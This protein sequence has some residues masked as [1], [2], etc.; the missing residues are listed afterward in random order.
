M[1]LTVDLS[2][3]SPLNKVIANVS[4][5]EMRPLTGIYYGFP[6]VVDVENHVLGLG[7]H[8]RPPGFLK[9]GLLF[10]PLPK[11]WIILGPVRVEESSFA[12]VQRVQ[13]GNPNPPTKVGD[14][15]DK[16][17]AKWWIS[18]FTQDPVHILIDW[19]GISNLKDKV[20]PV[21]IKG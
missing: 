3:P 9:E 16:V 12:M 7:V 10:A 2:K 13:S 15:T 11:D 4:P 21:I 8:H 1:S 5:S 19:D 18:A 17:K 14:V 6:V 20:D